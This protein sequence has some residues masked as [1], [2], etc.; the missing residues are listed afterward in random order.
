MN[1]IIVE[2]KKWFSLFPEFTM[3]NLLEVLIIAFIIY[4][5]FLL[6][7]NSHAIALIKGIVVIFFFTLLAVVLKLDNILWILQ[8]FSTAAVIAVV[9]IFQPELRKGLE[10]IGNQRLVS[11]VI[12]FEVKENESMSEETCKQI[13]K[14]VFEMAKVKTGALIVIE[15]SEDLKDYI[16]SGIMIEG[17]VS[18]AL[19]INI[20]EKNTPLH[21]GAVIIRGNRVV[22]ATCYLPL[23]ENDSISKD[24]GTR[25]RAAIG[26]SEATDASILVV[27]EETGHISM[28]CDG[29]LTRISSNEQLYLA[30]EN[31]STDLKLKEKEARKAQR[32]RKTKRKAKKEADGKSVPGSADLREDGKEQTDGKN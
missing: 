19:L 28:A 16:S 1:E 29:Q 26:M 18:A 21:D 22:A 11:K 12:N 25:H 8:R 10:A 7:K 23:S 4:E 17:K 6:I 27:S 31:L 30:L 24:L 3:L 2:I 32:D 14:A 5:I 15:H 20:F 9:V 13:T